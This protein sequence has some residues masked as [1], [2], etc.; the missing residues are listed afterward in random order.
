M[1]LVLGFV[2]LVLLTFAA[3]GEQH[4]KIVLPDADLIDAGLLVPDAGSEPSDTASLQE[5]PSDQ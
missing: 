3:C 2:A 1:K 4:P 5:E